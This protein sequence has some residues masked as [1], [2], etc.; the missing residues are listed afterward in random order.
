MEKIEF[1]SREHLRR[2]REMEEGRESV[3]RERASPGQFDGYLMEKPKGWQGEAMGI[4]VCCG[5]SY[6]DALAVVREHAGGRAIW[7]LGAPGAAP[8]RVA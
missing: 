3:R 4:I 8:E 1:G 7:R 6:E 5:K 2:L